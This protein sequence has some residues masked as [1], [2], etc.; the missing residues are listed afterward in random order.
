MEAKQL[1]NLVLKFQVDGSDETFAEIYGEVIGK[2]KP[3]LPTIGKSIGANEHEITAVYEDVLIRCIGKYDGKTNF[4]NYF[5]YSV[6]TERA[7]FLRGRSRRNKRE[8]LTIDK[9]VNLGESEAATFEVKDEFNLEETVVTTKKADQ[10]QLID[11]LVRNE[12]ATTKAIVEAFL[13]HPN[14]TATAIAR[15]MGVHHSK[16][17]RTLK[18]LAANFNTQQYGNHTDYLVAL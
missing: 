5:N 13:A 16:V 8:F 14:P 11:S 3:K 7:Y 18:R 10:W 12:N 9:P 6:K 1:N 15:D 2:I 17:T 4:E